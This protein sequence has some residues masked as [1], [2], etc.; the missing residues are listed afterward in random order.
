MSQQELHLPE[1]RFYIHVDGG[2]SPSIVYHSLD[3]AKSRAAQLARQT[4]K[5][6]FIFEPTICV[7]P[8]LAPESEIPVVES[9][10]RQ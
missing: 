5:R 10:V 9:V 3:H 2:G 8:V 6:V 7:E 4:R 1:P